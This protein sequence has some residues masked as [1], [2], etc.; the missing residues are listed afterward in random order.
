VQSPAV[1]THTD[2]Y[3]LTINYGANGI[4]VT[5][6]RVGPFA[7]TGNHGVKIVSGMILAVKVAA[8]FFRHSH[9]YQSC[10]FRSVFWLSFL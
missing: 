2:A 3:N 7:K 10:Y 6:L 5:V 4:G 1:I 8:T 9:H